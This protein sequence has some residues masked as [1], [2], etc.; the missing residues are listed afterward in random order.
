MKRIARIGNAVTIN[1]NK[2]KITSEIAALN[3]TNTK[4]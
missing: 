2:A 3:A 1:V 4:V